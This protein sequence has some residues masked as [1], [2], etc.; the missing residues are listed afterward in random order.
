MSKILLFSFLL[1][2]FVSGF[3]VISAFASLNVVPVGIA[4]SAV[5]TGTCAITAG[6]KKS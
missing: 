2:V 1:L 5:G 3:I 6:I 4:S